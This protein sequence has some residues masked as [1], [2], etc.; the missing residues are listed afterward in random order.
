MNELPHQKFNRNARILGIGCLVLAGT[1]LVG[2]LLFFGF[3]SFLM[4]KSN[5][6]EKAHVQVTGTF[7]TPDYVTGPISGKTTNVVM[8]SYRKSWFTSTGKKHSSSSDSKEFLVYKPG[9]VLNA[10]GKKY[11]IIGDLL[12]RFNGK[13]DYHNLPSFS[14]ECKTGYKSIPEIPDALFG[15]D[16][17]LDQTL[18]DM[19]NGNCGPTNKSNL[20]IHEFCYN[21]SDTITMMGFLSNDTLFLEH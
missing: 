18:K 21:S 11:T 13:K 8:L 6:Y 16:R 1:F 20:T 17:D 9:T 5:E 7:E 2:I 15:I 19:M 10:N 3:F 14:L 4:K 12:Y